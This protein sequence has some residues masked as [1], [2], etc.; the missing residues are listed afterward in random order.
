VAPPVAAPPLLLLFA[1]RLRDRLPEA[2]RALRPAAAHIAQPT[3]RAL[4]VA[5][6]AAQQYGAAFVGE[7][8]LRQRVHATTVLGTQGLDLA[9]QAA[10]A[11]RARRGR[12]EDLDRAVLAERDQAGFFEYREQRRRDAR[13]LSGRQCQG[14]EVGGAALARPRRQCAAELVELVRTHAALLQQRFADGAVVLV[15]EQDA[16]GLLPV[17]AGAAGFLH[18]LLERC[19]RLVVDDVADI[20]LVDAQAEGAGR[21]HH[22]AA[23]GLHVHLLL[24]V[25]V[26]G[27]H[28]AVVAM[29]GD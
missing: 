9:A 27:G 20:G 25:A 13:P 6:V 16:V 5:E 18:V 2:R 1:L 7:R 10:G 22:G 15:V 3:G 24:V 21:D 14:L 17:A 12:L 23:A 4:F 11:L 19:R 28:L 29:R 8:I 26:V